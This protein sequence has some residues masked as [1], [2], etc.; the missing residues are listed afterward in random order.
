[1][2]VEMFRREGKEWLGIWRIT[3]TIDELKH[4]LNA[5]SVDIERILNGISSLKY[6]IH[7]L[8]SRCLC[9]AGNLNPDTVFHMDNGKPFIA[10]KHQNLDIS[11]SHSGIYSVVM[12]REAGK[13]CGIDIQ[14]Y[15]E[16]LERTAKRFLLPPE[17]EKM[18]L[19]REKM[20][21]KFLIAVW[22]AKEAVFKAMP[23]AG[24][25]HYRQVEVI[26]IERMNGISL[27]SNFNIRCKAQNKEILCRG[28]WYKKDYFC[29]YVEKDR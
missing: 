4:L 29:V 6:R 14:Q 26:S 7:R 17:K 16:A 12:V 1:M 19:F 15:T 18:A 5:S 22:C 10:D 9:L 28:F 24:S 8:S 21:E 11:I 13:P 23:S 25:P 2:P 27:L 20:G 3:E